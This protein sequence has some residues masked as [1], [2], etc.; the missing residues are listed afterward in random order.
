M[1]CTFARKVKQKVLERCA[2]PKRV[3]GN[4]WSNLDTACGLIG[5]HCTLIIFY[6]VHVRVL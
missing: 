3:W 1:R 6:A 4:K 5:G 2:G